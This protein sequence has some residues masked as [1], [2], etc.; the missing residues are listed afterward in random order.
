MKSIF[1][2]LLIFLIG[3]TSAQIFS[4]S[5]LIANLTYPVAFTITPDDRFFVTLK[6]HNAYMTNCD[7]SIIKV[8]DAQGN[9]I[10]N[11]YTFNGDSNL[12]YGE[13]GIIGICG[14]ENFTSNHYLYFYYNHAYNGDTAIRVMRLTDSGNVAVDPVVILNIPAQL[15][16]QQHVAGN[17]RSSSYYPGKIFISI[18]DLV[19]NSNPQD[20]SSPFGK[21]LRIN[22]DGTIPADN[23]YYDDGDPLVGNDDRIFSYGHRNPFDLCISSLNGKI[24]SSENG[25]NSW[26]EIN[27][28]EAGKNYGWP[29]CEGSYMFNS[30]TTLCTA[31][32]VTAPLE[33]WGAPLPVL[34]GIEF[35]TSSQIPSLTNHLLVAD[36]ANGNIYDCELNSTFDSVISRTLLADLTSDGG[37]T[38]IRQGYDGCIYAMKGGFTNNG[39][40]Y[41]LCAPGIGVE[42][43]LN[44]NNITIFPNPFMDN[45]TVQSQVEINIQ[46]YDIVGNTIFENEDYSTQIKFN[47]EL[48]PAGIYIMKCR[49][50]SGGYV[51]RRIIKTNN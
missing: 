1:T 39:A 11:F 16:L 14:D 46:L 40:I 4:Q 48:T 24:Y 47:T 6:G 33:N 25:W 34:T 8:F 2:L 5:T 38:T 29:M 32:G 49:Y 9:F 31:T 41:K 45:L 42:E 3:K 20:L 23:P 17:I 30:T 27:L 19:N 10:K 22:N 37:L 7:S 26:D 50:K 18:G 12:C 15:T 28:I 43:N 21:I 13:T 35:Y 44:P 36:N 51:V